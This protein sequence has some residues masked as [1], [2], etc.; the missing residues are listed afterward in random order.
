M[1]IEYTIQESKKPKESFKKLKSF[2]YKENLK[3]M[4]KLFENDSD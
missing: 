2:D 1:E 3:D 4:E